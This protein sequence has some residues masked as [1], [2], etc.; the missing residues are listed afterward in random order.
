MLAIAV[1]RIALTP[2]AATGLLGE[3]SDRSIGATA[4]LVQLFR[5]RAVR[6][7]GATCARAP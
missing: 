1:P 2:N 4:D 3:A 5:D 6:R 7:L